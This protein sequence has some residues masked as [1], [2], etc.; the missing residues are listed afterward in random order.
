MS[1]QACAELV[2]RG[3]PERFMATMAAPVPMRAAFFPLFAFNLEVAR[4]PLV[5]AEPMIAEM[6]LQWWSDTVEEIAAGGPV[7]R[8]EVATPLAAVASGPALALLRGMIEA[9]RADIGAVPFADWPAVDDYLL[10]T[11]GNLMAAAAMLTGAGDGTDLLRRY[12]AAAG[13]AAPRPVE[14]R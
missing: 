8:H 11:S 5:T 14:R 3:D 9:R 10:D 6:R 2:R 13:T 4:A 7:R 1:V 12:G